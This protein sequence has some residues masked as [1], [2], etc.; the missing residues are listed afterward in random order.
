MSKGG[1]EFGEGVAF[2][3]F[4]IIRAPDFF[5]ALIFKRSRAI[6][7]ER[8]RLEFLWRE[9]RGCESLAS[10]LLSG[11]P[12]PALI[13]VI[14]SLGAP[15]VVASLLMGVMPIFS[16]AILLAVSFYVPLKASLFL[17]SLVELEV[18][19]RVISYNVKRGN[20]QKRFFFDVYGKSRIPLVF[21]SALLLLWSYFSGA[22]FDIVYG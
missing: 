16:V 7:R 2:S 22:V 5:V 10:G 21:L 11:R 15:L 1:R 8:V 9:S 13:L 3:E 19:Y 4:G 14:V 6:M 12:I 20:F 18:S 17:I